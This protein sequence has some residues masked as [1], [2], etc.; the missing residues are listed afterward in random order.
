LAHATHP[1][2]PAALPPVVREPGAHV[3]QEVAW[4]APLYVLSFPHAVQTSALL[5]LNVPAGHGSS[6]LVP[7]HVY[8]P[9]QSEH[10]VWVLVDPPL[11]L[12]PAGQTSQLPA[13]A[14]LYFESLPH[15]VQ[16]CAPEA[17]KYPAP[18]VTRV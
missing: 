7:S 13:P 17:E 16:N 4:V 6:E 1:V 9:V 18:Q 14:E 15:C 12:R 10:D 5:L 11:V 3:K 8:P 2:R